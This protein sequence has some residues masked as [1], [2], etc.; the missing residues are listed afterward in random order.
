MQ[1]RE[2]QKKTYDVRCA[3]KLTIKPKVLQTKP[4]KI[5]RNSK[6]KESRKV[7]PVFEYFDD[8]DVSLDDNTELANTVTDYGNKLTGMQS[9]RKYWK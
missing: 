9:D 2:L 7:S 4:Q 8:V 5:K 3:D 1:R 6:V